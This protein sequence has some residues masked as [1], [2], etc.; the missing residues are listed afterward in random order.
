MNI[1]QTIFLA[2]AWGM[3]GDVGAGWMIAMMAV[4]VLFWGAVIFG[5]IWLI[6]GAFAGRPGPEQERRESPTDVLDRRFAEGAIS[7][8]DYRERRQVLVAGSP[9]SKGAHEDELAAPGA[10]GSR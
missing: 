9:E 1:A 10:G 5:I 6:R 8:E 4:M 2:D 3:H 7:V